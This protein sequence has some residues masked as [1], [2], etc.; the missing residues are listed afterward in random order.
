M[1]GDV[2]AA[3][4]R[5]VAELWEQLP[6][7]S[8]REIGRRVVPP[9]GKSA[10]AG[11]AF[12]LKL[13]R[14]PSPIGRRKAT[15]AKPAPAPKP[16]TIKQPIIRKPKPVEAKSNSPNTCREKKLP[17]RVSALPRIAAVTVVP[18]KLQRELRPL[19]WSFGCKACARRLFGPDQCAA[20]LL[21]EAA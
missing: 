12:R 11:I 20:Q 10:V 13:S 21:A 3:Q 1:A 9:L 6:R 19:V 17:R 8:V 18:P 15:V 4:K 7:L 14:R 2:L 16:R 5:Q